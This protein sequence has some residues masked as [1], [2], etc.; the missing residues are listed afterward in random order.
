MD[1]FH[2]GCGGVDFVD[3]N[4]NFTAGKLTLELSP[5]K[6]PPAGERVSDGEA[7]LRGVAPWRAPAYGASP[8]FP[9]QPHSGV[10]RFR[11][12]SHP[13]CCATEFVPH[14]GPLPSFPNEE[15]TTRNVQGILP[16]IGIWTCECSVC[17]VSGVDFVIEVLTL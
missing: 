4:L 2:T 14:Y 5:Q 9:S 6:S 7:S 12:P 11:P 10:R 8:P 3:Q 16:G 15:G 1:V 13:G 17:F